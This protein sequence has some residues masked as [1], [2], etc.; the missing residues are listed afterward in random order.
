MTRPKSLQL[1]VDLYKRIAL[2]LS[3]HIGMFIKLSDCV[4]STLVSNTSFK[5]LA[6]MAKTDK[7]MHLR[8][9]RILASL[10][11]KRIQKFWRWCRYFS[12]ARVVVSRFRLTTLFS[13]NLPASMTFAQLD[14]HVKTPWILAAS[15]V[16][17]DRIYGLSVLSLRPRVD[18]TVV[19][20]VR[21]RVFLSMFMVKYYPALTFD[22]L[23]GELEIN[24]RGAAD[25]LL[26]CMETIAAHVAATGSFS[27][28]GVELATAFPL[29][30][31]QYGD[32][33]NRW[34]D[35]EEDVLLQR[36]VP[37]FVALIRAAERLPDNAYLTE[38][39]AQLRARLLVVVGPAA[40][41]QL[42]HG[43]V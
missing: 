25:A 8:M 28:V 6:M 42:E 34:R 1:A 26:L 32:A 27:G 16:F 18:S 22:N 11:A 9:N 3:Q 29:L 10:S 36:L 23:N 35:V 15:K 41:A 30:V 13:G 14:A 24:L 33:F 5:H 38:N 43:D 4:L 12:S 20:P 21:H 17:I 39:I 40:V 7:T 37:A 2:A 19:S 31:A